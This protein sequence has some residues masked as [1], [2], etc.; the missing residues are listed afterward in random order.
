MSWTRHSNHA[1]STYPY[2]RRVGALRGLAAA[3]LLG[4]GLAACSEPGEGDCEQGSLN[5]PCFP[6]FT[7]LGGLACSGTV[8]TSPAG[9][10]GDSMG[11][12]G[13]TGGTSDTPTTGNTA[14]ST[15]PTTGNPTGGTTSGTEDGGPV[16]VDFG[17]NVKMITD[18]ESVIFTATLTDPDGPDD[19][20]GGSLKTADES[21]TYGAFTDIGN[22]TYELTLSW[23]AIDQ[24]IGIEFETSATVGFKAVFFDNQGKKGF[25][26]TSIDLT[27]GADK[28]RI[29]CD[30][31]CI[32][33]DEDET[34]CGGCGNAC[35]V[36]VSC[37]YGTCDSALSQCIATASSPWSTCGEYCQS[38]G[39]ACVAACDYEITVLYWM[40]DATCTGFADG[41][42][43]AGYCDETTLFDPMFIKSVQCCCTSGAPFPP[44]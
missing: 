8:C 29:A 25:A 30:G 32:Q 10:S 21:V 4:L 7:C 2:A 26:T 36:G 11:S 16:V 42:V 34:N 3:F 37:F 39:E 41:E 23:A 31:H 15:S 27:C 13:T 12:A 33:A 38:K 44:P 43:G 22:G 14:T 24:A 20:Q 5:C 6:N 40:G 18:G 28:A 35:G 19:I 9:S 1:T 17:T